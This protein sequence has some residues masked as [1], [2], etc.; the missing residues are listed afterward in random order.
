MRYQFFFHDL[1]YLRAI[2][3]YFFYFYEFSGFSLRYIG[4]SGVFREI[5]VY[6]I[7]D[8]LCSPHQL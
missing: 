7:I 3:L 4:K 6:T 8:L 1:R 2:G 5:C